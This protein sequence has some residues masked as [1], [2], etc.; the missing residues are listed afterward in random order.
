MSNE[1][2]TIGTVAHVHVE[3]RGG[4]SLLLVAIDIEA[5]NVITPKDQLLYGRGIPMKVDDHGRIRG[6]QGLKHLVIQ[7]VR[8]SCLF[9]QHEQGGNIDH[10]H[11]KLCPFMTIYTC[12][13]HDSQLHVISYP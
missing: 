6:E 3:W 5:P 12:I 11:S 7:A 2:V 8:M 1:V 9:L 13:H 10:A 4:R